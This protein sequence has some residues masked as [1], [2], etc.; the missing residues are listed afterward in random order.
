LAVDHAL[1][2]AGHAVIQ[3]VMGPF[4]RLCV[5]LSLALLAMPVPSAGQP[6][7]QRPA[8]YLFVL[9][10][11][12]TPLDEFPTG[13]KALAGVM[14]VVDK[15]GRHMLMASSPSELLITLPQLLPAVFTVELDIVPKRCCNPD[16]I[17]VEG[18]PTRNRGV[19]SAELTWHPSRI[20][21]VGG[22]GSMYQSDMPAD[23]A[24]ATPGNLTHL[25]MEF[26]GTTIKL[27]TNG[28][29]LY[30]L[31]KQFVRGRVLRVGLGGESSG[32]PIYL[33]GLRV[34]AGPAAPAVAQQQ[35]GLQSN[36]NPE[37]IG[38]STGGGVR[39]AG[40]TIATVAP[41]TGATATSGA[42]AGA[43][44]TGPVETATSRTL[45]ESRAALFAP[46]APRSIRLT[47][48]DGSGLPPP[49]PRKISLTGFAGEG[50]PPVNLSRSVRLAGFA[51]VGRWEIP[52]PRTIRLTGLTGAGNAREL[53][54]SMR[55]ASDITPMP[56]PRSLQLPG[57]MGQG[58]TVRAEP[59]SI[60]LT[61]FAGTGEAARLAP[62]RIVL[63]GFNWSGGAG[64][65]APRAIRLPGWTGSGSQPTP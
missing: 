17:M 38:G 12:G 16:D 27:Y 58:N 47:G 5:G 63:P 36:T 24:A 40:G 18:M 9:D 59:R 8:P 31:E 10:L 29:R 37:T 42:S 45:T 62:R 22:G 30:T 26:N 32:N 13:V 55:V 14:T 28:Q 11:A 1:Y 44:A 64:D 50:V 52:A 61:A 53:S 57:F 23:L 41:A 3:R 48:Y 46:P 25:V 2:E 43:V 65:A 4:L 33:A 34:G 6:N 56:V 15:D 39:P 7:V 35:S 60:R 49:P 21:V 19:A 20:S 51:G 54:T